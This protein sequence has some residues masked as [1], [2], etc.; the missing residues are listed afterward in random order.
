MDVLRSTAVTRIARRKKGAWPESLRV[1]LLN[2]PASAQML[3]ELR[4]D[5]KNAESG[6]TYGPG[7]PAASLKQI[8]K[9]IWNL[10]LDNDGA[11]RRSRLSTTAS[12]R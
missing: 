7:Y 3:D 2:V 4:N 1:E 12:C 11:D 9:S 5:G 10:V 6:L 8:D